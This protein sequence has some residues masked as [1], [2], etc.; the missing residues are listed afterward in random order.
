MDPS[1]STTVFTT[2]LIFTV[3]STVFTAARL[4]SKWAIVKRVNVDDFLVLAAWCF[5]AGMGFSIM[6][7]TRFGLGDLDAGECCAFPAHSQNGNGE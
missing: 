7:G 6:Y 2:T 3:L 4:A 5:A 1:R